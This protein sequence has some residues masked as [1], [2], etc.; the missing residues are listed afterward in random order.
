MLFLSNIDQFSNCLLHY[1][2]LQDYEGM[3]SNISDTII[4]KVLKVMNR[5][6]YSPCHLEFYFGRLEMIKKHIH[7]IPRTYEYYS[8]L[9]KLYH[10]REKNFGRIIETKHL[11]VIGQTNLRSDV[12]QREKFGSKLDFIFVQYMLSMLKKETLTM[13]RIKKLPT[14]VDDTEITRVLEELECE[15]IRQYRERFYFNV[16][17]KMPS[18]GNNSYA[19]DVFLMII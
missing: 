8:N 11:N 12:L 5:K 16:H 7:R 15:I 9:N 2:V 3:L 14:H 6:G 18:N 13:V 10:G 19:L 4:D 17:E 1:C